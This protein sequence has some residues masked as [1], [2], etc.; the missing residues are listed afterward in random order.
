[1]LDY[2]C[3]PG[4]ITSALYGRATEFVGID[5][6]DNMV[7][8]YNDRFAESEQQSGTI[9]RTAKAVV[10]D[11]LNSKGPSESISGP[12]FSDFDL[13]IVGYGF[14]HF[15]DLDVATSRLASRLKPGG[16]LA[17]VDLVTHA[18]L[19]ANDPSKDIVAHHGFGEEEVKHIFGKAGLV[20]VAVREM[21]VMV[22]MKRP[23]MRE[24]EPGKMRKVFLGRGRKPA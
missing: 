22:E 7:K 23:G 19:E 12:E 13:A 17:I 2:A 21:E 14:H 9:T 18:K 6:S 20:D 4:T 5:L 15:E 16:V 8:A 1:V 3:G 10:G 11:L 24:G